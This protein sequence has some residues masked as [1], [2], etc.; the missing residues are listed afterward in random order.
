ME[1]DKIHPMRY[2]FKI[3]LEDFKTAVEYYGETSDFVSLPG[4]LMGILNLSQTKGLDLLQ[5]NELL[6]L[7]FKRYQIMVI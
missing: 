1:Y 3:L 4:S 7:F 6:F 2:Q 5:L